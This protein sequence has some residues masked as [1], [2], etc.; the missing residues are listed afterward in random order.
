LDD[1]ISILIADDHPLM[2]KGLRLSVE[3]DPGL[4]VVGEASDGEAALSLI[5]KLR[6]N[7]AL[8]DIEMPKLDGLGVAREIVKRG[9]KTEIIFLTLHSNQ[10]LFRSAMDLGCKGYILKDSAVQEVVAGIHAVASGRPYISSA[11]TADLLHSR[12]QPEPQASHPLT[13]NLTPTELRIMRLIVQGKTSKEIGAELSIHY[14]T[15]EN[16]R[17]SMCRKLELEGEGANALLRF[18]LQNKNLL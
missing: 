9:L 1:T 3:E 7:V 11:I 6:P 5:T 12:N 8:L 15:V 17:T 4:K 10:D 18:A 13:G 2:R 16:H 14:R